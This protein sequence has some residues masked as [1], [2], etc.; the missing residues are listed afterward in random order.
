MKEALEARL[1][2]EAVFAVLDGANRCGCCISGL[3]A[4]ISGLRAM[5]APRHT[6][7]AEVL[8]KAFERLFAHTG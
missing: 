2:L 1:F 6:L 7:E 4:A 3:L 8:Q 5:A